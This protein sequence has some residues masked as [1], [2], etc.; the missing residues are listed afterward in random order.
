VADFVAFYLNKA[1]AAKLIKEVGY[2][3]LPA[4]AYDFFF[5]RFK[6]RRTGTAFVGS[7]V[8]VSVEDL[9]KAPLTN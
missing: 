4:H 6:D 1:N 7:K 2:V 8:G 9:L 5:Q 3:P